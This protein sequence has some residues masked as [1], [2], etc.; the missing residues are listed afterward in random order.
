MS[1]W[2]GF[3]CFI[4]QCHQREFVQADVVATDSFDLTTPSSADLSDGL[5]SRV[6]P[7]DALK[8]DVW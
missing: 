4:L 7:S 1:I 8:A 3:Y 2:F 5:R 6:D